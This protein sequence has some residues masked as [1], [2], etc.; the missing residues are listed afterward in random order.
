MFLAGALLLQKASV[1]VLLRAESGEYSRFTYML[2][3]DE[4]DLVATFI[5]GKAQLYI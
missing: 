4:T 2:M 3:F 1:N 5:Q